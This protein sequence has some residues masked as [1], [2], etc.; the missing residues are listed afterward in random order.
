[1]GRVLNQAPRLDF[2]PIHNHADVP[3]LAV[4]G[5]VDGELIHR[6]SIEYRRTGAHPESS[7]ASAD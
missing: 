1:M 7:E 2:L 3:A 6:P 5:E 4:V